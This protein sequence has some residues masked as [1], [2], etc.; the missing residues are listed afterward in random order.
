MFAS[1]G[2]IR[3]ILLR[4]QDE[5]GLCMIVFECSLGGFITEIAVIFL[6][7]YY[8]KPACFLGTV[9]QVI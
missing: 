2:I 5:R 9:M 1:Y 3:S 4:K 6:K 8:M 7:F